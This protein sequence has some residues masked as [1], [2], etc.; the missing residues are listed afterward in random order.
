MCV[1]PPSETSAAAATLM[2]HLTSLH[3]SADPE[4]ADLRFLGG[5]RVKESGSERENT[6]Q[7]HQKDLNPKIRTKTRSP[8]FTIKNKHDEVRKTQLQLCSGHQLLT[9]GLSLWVPVT[10]DESWSN[11]TRCDWLWRTVSAVQAE[12]EPRHTCV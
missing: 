1:R 10:T 7:Q 3:Q 5:E 4:S 8:V 12:E 2:I 9:T 11:K 6:S